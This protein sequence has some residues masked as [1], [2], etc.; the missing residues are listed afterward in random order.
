MDKRKKVLIAGGDMRQ[1]YCGERLFGKYGVYTIGIEK[2]HFPDVLNLPEADENMSGE[3]SCAILPVPPPDESGNIF[4]PLFSGTINT[5]YVKKLLKSDAVVFTGINSMKMSDYFPS[6]RI[7]SYMDREELAV[8]NAV[9]TAEGAVMLA[10]EKLPVTLNGLPVL[11]A[12]AGRIGMS[13]AIILKGFGADITMAVHNSKGAAK[14]GLLGVKSVYTEK[15][16]GGYG[17]VFNTVPSVIFTED[18]LAK[19]SEETLFIDLASRPG[20][21]DFK[22]AEKMGKRVIWALGIPGKNAPKTAGAAVADTIIEIM[23]NVVY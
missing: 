9:P 23:E 14:A 6:H 11:I 8:K 20:G 18:V 22:S 12:G 3:F 15:I 21:F 17:L 5:A 7:F 16:D 10:L 19:F 13:L 4:T 1:I 2:E